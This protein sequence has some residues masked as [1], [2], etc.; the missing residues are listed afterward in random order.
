ME[1]SLEDN[2]DIATSL[3]AYGDEFINDVH[4]LLKKLRK[5]E[6]KYKKLF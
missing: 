2:E 1:I 6:K 3:Q 4:D 5:F